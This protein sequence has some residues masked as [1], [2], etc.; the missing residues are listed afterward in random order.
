MGL[1]EGG[2]VLKWKHNE[3]DTYSKVPQ[4]QV[5]GRTQRSTEGKR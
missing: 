1:P 3:N 4:E 5:L 2:N